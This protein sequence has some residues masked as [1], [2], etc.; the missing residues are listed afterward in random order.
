MPK[1]DGI[2]VLQEKR[3]RSIGGRVLILSARDQVTDRVVLL[4]L[5]ADDYLVKPFSFDE[6]RARI[7]A[8]GRRSQSESSPV[9]QIGPVAIDQVAKVARIDQAALPLTP[10]EYLL[11][12]LLMRKR[13]QVLSRQQIFDQLYDSQSDASDRVVEV[14]MSTLRSK[15]EASN[16]RNFVQ[17]RR[18]FGYVVE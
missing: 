7:E 9:L 12:E 18:G 10:K 13:G 4:D 3:K 17:T 6:L 15:L 1:I 11:L 8:L 2:G 16:A 14:L 5:G